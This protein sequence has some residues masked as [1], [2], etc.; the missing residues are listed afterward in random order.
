MAMNR[1]ANGLIGA[2]VIETSGQGHLDTPGG[3][4]HPPEP[5]EV[6]GG[7]CQ[8]IRRV[9]VPAPAPP[10]AVEIDAVIF[11]HLWHDLGVPH[12]PRP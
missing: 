11:Q 5:G 9:I 7:G 12:S 4:Q 1:A 10:V 3:A 8:R 6:I 2:G